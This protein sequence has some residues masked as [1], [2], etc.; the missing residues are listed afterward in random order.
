MLGAEGRAAAWGEAGAGPWQPAIEWRAPVWF[1]GGGGGGR[2]APAGSSACAVEV[3]GGG[4]RG[5]AAG[6]PRA[7]VGG[8]P[9]SAGPAR[10][11]GARGD[12]PL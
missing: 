1:G 9:C 12:R 10:V 5:Q 7:R 8:H 3:D 11:W 6:A 2:G 4:R